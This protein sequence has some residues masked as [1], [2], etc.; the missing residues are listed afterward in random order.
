MAPAALAEKAGAPKG[1]HPKDLVT[2]V[3][4]IARRDRFDGDVTLD[5]LTLKCDRGLDAHWA[6]AIEVPTARCS[7]PGVN[8]TGLAESK[9]KF[10]RVANRAWG[11]CIARASSSCPPTT[12]RSWAAASGRSSQASAP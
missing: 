1:V 8:E 5:S 11:A 6:T 9:V 3:D 4:V 12:S 7:A 10:R 2:E